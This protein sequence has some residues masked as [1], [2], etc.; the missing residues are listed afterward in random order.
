MLDAAR[1]ALLENQGVLVH[2]SAGVGRTGTFI[3]LLNLTTE[4]K[5]QLELWKE[6]KPLTQG[7]SIFGTVR[8]LREQRWGMVFVKSQYQFLY[9]FL[10]NYIVREFGLDEHKF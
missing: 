10:E 1:E 8:K 9:E 6:N 2:C 4:L 3:A 7:V 5:G